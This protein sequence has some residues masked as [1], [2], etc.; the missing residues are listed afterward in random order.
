MSLASFGTECKGQSLFDHSPWLSV[1]TK[2][3]SSNSTTVYGQAQLSNFEV[4]SYQVDPGEVSIGDP[5]DISTHANRRK[6]VA[7]GWLNHATPSPDC[8]SA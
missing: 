3:Q 4:W 6:R 5:I 7:F 2:A 1:V 8:D